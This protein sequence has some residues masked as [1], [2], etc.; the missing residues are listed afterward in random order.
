ME[1]KI[2][3]TNRNYVRLLLTKTP[4]TFSPT[5]GKSKK[6]EKSSKDTSI[7]LQKCCKVTEITEE[8]EISNFETRDIREVALHRER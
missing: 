8:S 6:V 3:S 7:R 1:A 2:L 5:I 4:K